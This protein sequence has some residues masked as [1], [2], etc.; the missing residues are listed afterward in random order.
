MDLADALVNVDAVIGDHT[1]FQVVAR[2]PDGVFVVENL[3]KGARFTRMRLA[4]DTNARK[5][6]Y[7]TAD[8]HKPWNIGVA[9]DAAIQA[10]L[11]TSTASSRRFWER[12]SAVRP[13]SSRAPMPAAGPTDGCA[14]RSWRR[15]RRCD[16]ER[17]GHR[18]RHHQLGRHPGGSDVSDGGQSERLLS[19][20]HAPALPDHPW[21]GAGSLAV[22]QYR[23]HAA[24]QRRRAEDDAGERGVEHAR[25][26]R[27][28]RPDFGPV[29]PSRPP[30]GPG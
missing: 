24:G 19:A 30:W 9:P 26:Q 17:S 15:H 20:V 12:S 18:L 13:G 25:G 7:I 14:S 28:V 29:L 3:S 5:V 10:R 6:V 1:G 23:H 27:P 11:T 21:A 4:L 16:A 8:F 22:R 2:R